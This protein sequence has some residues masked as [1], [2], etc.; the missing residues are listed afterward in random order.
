[1]VP[2]IGAR[3]QVGYETDRSQLLHSPRD[4]NNE[5]LRNGSALLVVTI[6]RSLLIS[7]SGDS[8]FYSSGGLRP[9]TPCGG[10]APKPRVGALLLVMTIQRYDL[11]RN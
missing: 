9:Q 5:P 6:P 3:I 10:S 4:S 8:G 1:M 2:A 11:I 7:G